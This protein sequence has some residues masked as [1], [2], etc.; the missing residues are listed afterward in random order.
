MFKFHAHA[1]GQKIPRTLTITQNLLKSGLLVL[2]ATSRSKLLAQK[3]LIMAKRSRTWCF[4][5]NEC[6]EEIWNAMECKYVVYG[7]EVAPSTG[8]AHLQGFIQF[9]N[10]M[11]FKRVKELHSTAH[12]EVARSADASE[13]YCKKDGD[14]VERGTRPGKGQGKRTDLEQVYE[15]IKEGASFREVLEIHPAAA[16]QYSRGIQQAIAAQIDHRSQDITPEVHWYYGLPGTGKSRAAF[17]EAG[18]DAY[19][20]CATGKFWEGYTGQTKVIL[21]DFRPADMPFAVL[22]RV[23]DRYRYTV[24]TKGASCPLAA[25]QFW[26]TTPLS[27]TDTYTGTNHVTGETWEKE[28]IKQLTRRVSDVRSFA[29]PL[30]VP[31]EQETKENYDFIARNE[32]FTY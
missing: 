21:D 7:R 5:D 31:T 24:E 1:I 15:A 23:I 3:L 19:V 14:F 6:K 17:A 28:N 25:T 2:Q 11:S 13:I 18:E 8:Q 32:R 22:L 9:A 10:D 16:I 4:T 27:P 30:H 20:W 26:I 12:W 29:H